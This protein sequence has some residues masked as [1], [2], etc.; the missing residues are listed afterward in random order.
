VDCG[1]KVRFEPFVGIAPKRYAEFF[2]LSKR[3]RKDASG[4]VLPW[5]PY[6]ANPQLPD[7]MPSSVAT[8]TGEEEAFKL[9]MDAMRS[10]NLTA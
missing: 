9:F 3:R 10:A 6:E 7:Y 1:D 8:L 2:A 4:A 5:R